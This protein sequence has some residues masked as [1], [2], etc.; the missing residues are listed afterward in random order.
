MNYDGESI[1]IELGSDIEGI[2]SAME[3]C[4]E[5]LCN[6]LGSYFAHRIL[7]EGLAALVNDSS[8]G[9]SDDE[10]DDDPDVADAG[11]DIDEDQLIAQKT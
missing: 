7:D 9:K 10:C 3:A 6:Q 4:A 1:T 11:P 5:A 8:K 2:E